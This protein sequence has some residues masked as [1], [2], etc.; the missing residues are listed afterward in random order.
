[1]AEQHIRNVRIRGIAAAVPKRSVETTDSREFSSAD[2]CVKF[3]KNVGIER[4][5]IHDGNL[6]SSDL[7]LAAAE[8][9]M[10]EVGWDKKEIDLLVFVTQTQDYI[11]PA[12]ACVLHGRMG[13]PQSCACFDISM[14]CSGWVYGLSAVAG[15]MQTGAFRKVLLLAGDAK[16]LVELERAKPLFGCSGTATLL[17]YD[18]TASEMTIDTRTDGSGAEA[19][20]KRAG[21]TRC[22]FSAEALEWKEDA[23]GNVHRDIDTEMDGAAVFIFGITQVPRAIK[24]ML[25]L[26]GKT[27]EDIDY[28]LL[29]QAN[30]MMDEQIRRKCKFPEEKCPYSLADF[31]NNS[32]GSIPLTMVTQLRDSLQTA[33]KEILACGFGVGL[34]WGTLQMR[35]QCPVIPALIEI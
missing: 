22:P 6:C 21:A 35:T 10:A 31:G 3:V 1:M 7:C 20:I 33:E 23:F 29:H 24:N 19:I 28:L 11:L 9:V 25:K 34:S 27:V 14:G 4:R 5:R 30:L 26:T 12:T 8:Q 16:T 32:S 17:E 13:L 15:M 18:S 2:E